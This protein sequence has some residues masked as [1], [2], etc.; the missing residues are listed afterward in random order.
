[1]QQ[2]NAV[3]DALFALK[4]DIL[5]IYIIGAE[6]CTCGISSSNDWS[7]RTGRSGRLYIS[8]CDMLLYYKEFL[9]E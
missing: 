4:G 5:L 8:N 6:C 2:Y 1:M 7:V 3:R 9:I